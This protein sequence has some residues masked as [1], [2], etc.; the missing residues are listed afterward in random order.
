MVIIRMFN[1]Q[2]EFQSD[3]EA[4]RFLINFTS[5]RERPVRFQRLSY[6]RGQ[7]QEMDYL[8]IQ[9]GKVRETYNTVR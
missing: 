7:L 5:T 3:E 9:K 2:Y 1:V 4:S 8:T 6:E